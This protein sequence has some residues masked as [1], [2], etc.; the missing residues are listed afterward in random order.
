[1][2]FLHFR[3]QFKYHV[4]MY[5]QFGI[6][7][8]DDDRVKFDPNITDDNFEKICT[9][10]GCDPEHYFSFKFLDVNVSK[11][12]YNDATTTEDDAQDI[13]IGQPVTLEG[14]LV[15]VAPTAEITQFF[16]QPI[17]VANQVLNGKPQKATDSHETTD[18]RSIQV[19]IRPIVVPPGSHVEYYGAYF[20]TNIIDV[21]ITDNT[22]II[23]SSRYL[24]ELGRPDTLQLYFYLNRFYYLTGSDG[25]KE[26]LNQ[27]TVCG[28]IG[29]T[30]STEINGLRIKNRRLITNPEVIKN[31]ENEIYTDFR[32][33]RGT[34]WGNYDILDR[35]QLLVLHYN[36]FIPWMDENLQTLP[37]YN[38]N[39]YF[40]DEDK[41]IVN[42]VLGEFSVDSSYMQNSG[43]IRVFKLPSQVLNGKKA[44]LVVEAL[45]NGTKR[46]QL[47]IE[48]SWDLILERVESEEF[49]LSETIISD[50]TITMGSGELRKIIG[51][52]YYSNR[53]CPNKKVYLSNIGN[54]ILPKGDKGYILR[55][56]VTNKLT[57]DIVATFQE[58]EVLTG[59]DGS[60]KATLKS[61]D[62]ENHHWEEYYANSVS[63]Q[64][65]TSI[66]ENET[67]GNPDLYELQIPVRVLHVVSPEK[68]SSSNISFNNDIINLFTYYLKH[69]PWL[70]VKREGTGFKKF[71]DLASFDDV[72]TK[73]DKILEKIE[74]EDEND[75]DKM[76]RS[77]DFPIKGSE[78]IRRWKELGKME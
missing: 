67:D 71:L 1:M 27:G 20:K 69:Y 36:D 34:L 7:A 11:I 24:R 21:Q 61:A 75:K 70:H 9:T 17:E 56:N 72:S 44:S 29:P 74:I 66:K 26:V 31:A 3:G 14:Y 50:N 54:G 77:R 40:T 52:V 28:Y 10:I 25:S 12:T 45:K 22:S 30:V 47:M 65:D 48:P 4:P 57:A 2:P 55:Q 46:T 60:F 78:L 76:P 73:V 18:S 33:D 53:P 5:N 38:Y 37:N 64:I 32:L 6:D 8:R 13:I 58:K 63:M 43:G 51:R 41:S 62:L 23:N 16:P 42:V 49:S 15:D 39:V 59:P 68:L 19:N 35:E